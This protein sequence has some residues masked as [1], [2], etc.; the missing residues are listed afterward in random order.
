MF[1]VDYRCSSC[2]SNP[3]HPSHCW[4]K[5]G[6]VGTFRTFPAGNETLQLHSSPPD[7]FILVG[8]RRV[9]GVENSVFHT[10]IK[11]HETAWDMRSEPSEQISELKCTFKI[12]QDIS[13]YI[14]IY[15]DIIEVWNSIDF[16]CDNSTCDSVHDTQSLWP[17]TSS[18]P[19]AVQ[20]LD[21]IVTSKKG[22]TAPA[23]AESH[24]RSST[25][26]CIEKRCKH[27][28]DQAQ[29]CNSVYTVSS[30][31]KHF[32]RSLPLLI[33]AWNLHPVALLSRLSGLNMQSIFRSIR[34]IHV[35]HWSSAQRSWNPVKATTEASNTFGLHEAFRGSDFA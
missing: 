30:I 17:G 5:V 3:S 29:N 19:F 12:Y 18:D 10:Q 34:S 4:P 31:I 21:V 11:Q 23:L 7:D 25:A 35:L 22:T 24:C 20:F 8:V 9:V 14:K 26:L 2:M 32:W 6:T 1:Y 16:N 33:S 15:Q 27:K 28:N 13:R